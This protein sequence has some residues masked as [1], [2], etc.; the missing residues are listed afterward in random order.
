[1]EIREWTLFAI[2]YVPFALPGLVVWFAALIKFIPPPRL[3]FLEFSFL[4]Q[5]G[6]GNWLDPGQRGGE[7]GSWLD[8]RSSRSNIDIRRANKSSFFFFPKNFIA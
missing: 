8:Q 6:V 3:G 5:A 1:M 4:P 2:R 7:G